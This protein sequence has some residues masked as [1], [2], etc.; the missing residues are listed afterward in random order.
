MS[1][2]R[3]GQ[4]TRCL[5]ATTTDFMLRKV[6]I[7]PAEEEVPGSDDTTLEN[8]EVETQRPK[9]LK[10]VGSIAFKAVLDPAIKAAA[11]FGINQKITIE[12]PDG[13]ADEYYGFLSKCTPAG[14]KGGDRGMVDCLILVSN[15]NG[16][17]E[18]KP[19]FVAAGS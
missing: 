4:G 6:E 10:K 8:T 7:T 12:Y 13:D 15:L 19:N 18:T 3:D 14:I 16:D 9:T 5:F 1:E 2:V 11:P 17:V